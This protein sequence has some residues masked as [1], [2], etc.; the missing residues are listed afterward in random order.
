MHALKKLCSD[1]LDCLI[2]LFLLAVC[3]NCDSNKVYT[4]QLDNESLKSS[5]SL[6]SLS[7]PPPP[8]VVMVVVAETVLV[9]Y[10]F[11]YFEFCSLP[12]RVSFNVFFYQ[13]C[14]LQIV[15]LFVMLSAT[16]DHSYIH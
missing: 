3:L 6:G 2:T 8:F 15:F 4:L 1:F 13:L 12:S 10:S 16:E 7:T 9:L 5:L 11:P 14:F